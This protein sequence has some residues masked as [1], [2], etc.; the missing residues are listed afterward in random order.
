MIYTGLGTLYTPPHSPLFRFLHSHKSFYI[1]PF[2]VVTFDL[3]FLK[4]SVN[5]VDMYFEVDLS[6]VSLHNFMSFLFVHG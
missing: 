3:T 2:I 6:H 5:L 4:D 1:Q